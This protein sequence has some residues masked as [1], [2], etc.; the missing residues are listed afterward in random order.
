MDL[1]DGITYGS[2]LNDALEALQKAE[3][4]AL[5][6]LLALEVI[7]E[8][9]NPLDALSN[10]HF[11]TSGHA[12]EP[13]NVL[14]YMQLATEQTKLLNSIVRTL[15]FARTSQARSQ[16]NLCLLAEA[17][18]RIHA[19]SIL[20]KHVRVVKELADEVMAEVHSGEVLQVVS[21]LLANA[22]D[23][24]SDNGVIRLRLK[25]SKAFVR[26]I[27]VDNGRGVPRH[28]LHKIF[29]PFFTTKDERG[30]G[31]GLALSKKIIESHGGCVRIRSRVQAGSSGT[32]FRIVLPA[33]SP[34]GP[35]RQ[36]AN[37]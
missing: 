10:L 2:R 14:Y 9:R 31:L 35:Q 23:A 29:E 20:S 5:A 12:G 32:L 7:H 18:L 16:L 8:I 17:A 6:G 19:K 4:R 24:L 27:I 28:H 13:D 21:N 34:A 15:G 30:T 36:R 26:I 3:Q 11:L 37:A 25:S 1:G 22:L 33:C